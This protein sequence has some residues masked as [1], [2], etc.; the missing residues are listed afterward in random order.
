MSSTSYSSF[1]L[2]FSNCSRFFR[3][4]GLV[5]GG[6]SLDTF[7]LKLSGGGGLSSSLSLAADE[8]GL[9]LDISCDSLPEPIP[10]DDVKGSSAS[11][12]DPIPRFI[13]VKEIVELLVE[14]SG[15][16]SSSDSSDNAILFAREGGTCLEM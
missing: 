2:D 9:E 3:F 8:D 5:E 6:M 13:P 16:H 4:V 11:V 1:A 10:S 15:I 14:N 7:E 12:C